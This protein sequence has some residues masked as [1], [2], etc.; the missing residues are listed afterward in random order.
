[1]VNGNLNIFPLIQALPEEDIRSLWDSSDKQDLRIVSSINFF[2]QFYCAG[3]VLAP[4]LNQLAN[5]KY[6]C[7][8]CDFEIIEYY[9]DEPEE[10]A[11]GIHSYL[12]RKTKYKLVIL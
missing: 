4:D 2:K 10:P 7:S 12:T 11:D 9:A 8:K 3:I 6:L 5:V 1:M